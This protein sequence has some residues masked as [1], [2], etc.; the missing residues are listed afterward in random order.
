MKSKDSI[1]SMFTV[2][3]KENREQ[4]RDKDGDI[5]IINARYK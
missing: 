3:I 1:A 4:F 2:S 5:A